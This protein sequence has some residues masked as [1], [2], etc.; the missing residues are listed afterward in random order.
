MSSYGCHSGDRKATPEYRALNDAWQRKALGG[1]KLMATPSDV[2]GRIF[3][4]PDAAAVILKDVQESVSADTESLAGNISKSQLDAAVTALC[5]INN[6]ITL[7]NATLRDVVAAV[8]LLR[9]PPAQEPVG[10]WRDMN[11]EAMN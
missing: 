9:E 5:E 8:E 2:R 3:I 7:L 4:D 10:S 6:G 1:W 11:G